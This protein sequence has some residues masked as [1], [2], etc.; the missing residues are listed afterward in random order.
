[1]VVRDVEQWGQFSDEVPLRPRTWKRCGEDME[2]DEDRAGELLLVGVVVTTALEHGARQL[3]EVP[4]SHPRRVVDLLHP[5]RRPVD[6]IPLARRHDV[7]QDGVDRSRIVPVPSSELG[8]LYNP[9]GQ[10]EQREEE[11]TGDEKAAS[12]VLTQSWAGEE[13]HG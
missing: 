8:F 5:S 2:L 10:V 7:E 1:M 6:R 12:R 4:L 13:A 9:Q 11:E 3:G